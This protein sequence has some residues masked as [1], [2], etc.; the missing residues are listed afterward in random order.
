[1]AP[2]GFPEEFRHEAIDLARTSGKTKTM[3]ALELGISRE[4]LRRWLREDEHESGDHERPTT[5]ER[6]EIRRLRRE[7]EIAN[8]EKEILKKAAAFFAKESE[9]R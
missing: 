9:T 1:V 5:D 6:K 3:I 4:T 7:L 8:K 2:R